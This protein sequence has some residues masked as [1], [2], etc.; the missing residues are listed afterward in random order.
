ML[1]V[2]FKKEGSARYTS[3][4]DMQR[5]L[6]RM[7]RRAGF[8]PEYSGGFHPHVLL[9]LSPPIP[10]GVESEAEYFTLE[11]KNVGAKEF[12]DGMNKVAQA[13]IFVTMATEIEKNP[14]VAGNAVAAEYRIIG[15]APWEKIVAEKE[16]FSVWKKDRKGNLTKESV[17]D[18]IFEI[19]PEVNGVRVKLAHGNVNLRI[20]RFLEAVNE[21]YGTNLSLSLVKKTALY[22]KDGSFDRYF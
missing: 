16:N 4:V 12:Q 1:F 13:G 15:E 21:N 9:K 3:H 5:T 22:F 2:K 14:N 20:D 7:I 10:L 19:V 11:I 8:T 6:N 17:G 18:K